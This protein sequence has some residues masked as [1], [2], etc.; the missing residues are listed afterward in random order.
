MPAEKFAICP[1]HG[2]GRAAD[3]GLLQWRKPTHHCSE[4]RAPTPKIVCPASP[5]ANGARWLVASRLEA[6]R[7]LEC[8]LVLMAPM[9]FFLLS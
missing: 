4:V 3:V 5:Q 2:T 7:W 8:T 6:R 9:P 1:G